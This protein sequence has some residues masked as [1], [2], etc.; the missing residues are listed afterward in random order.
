[1]GG[2]ATGYR[3]QL[4]PGLLADPTDGQFVQR[5]DAFY[6]TGSPVFGGETLVRFGLP[7]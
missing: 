2:T 4:R 6:R 7:V 5:V 1:M 3:G